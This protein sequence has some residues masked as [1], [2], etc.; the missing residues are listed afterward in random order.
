MIVTNLYCTCGEKLEA[1]F[2]K[3]SS[4]YRTVALQINVN[5]CKACIKRTQATD[6][7]IEAAREFTEYRHE[8]TVG[9]DEKYWKLR[10][11]L[12]AYDKEAK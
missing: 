2:G 6:A 9:G 1:T 12:E 11:A 8:H 4:D 3:G 10:D 7:V 5:P